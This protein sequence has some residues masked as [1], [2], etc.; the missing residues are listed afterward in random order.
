MLD[1]G[2]AA[3]LEA[4]MVPET[5]IALL[6]GNKS[7]GGI[8][9]PLDNPINDIDSIAAKLRVLDFDT[10]VLPDATF[11]DTDRA[12]KQYVRKLR[13][14]E[15]RPVGFFWYTGHGLMD[16]R[17]HT[18]YLIPTDITT[19][20]PAIFDESIGL[21]QILDL[22]SRDNQN[23]AQIVAFDAS[24]PNL[25]IEGTD[26]VP[27]GFAATHA[28][29]GMV[30]LFASSPGRP[31]YDESQA[32]PDHSP[33]AFALLE[34]LERPSPH[35][36]MLLTLAIERVVELTKK[37]SPVQQPHLLVSPMVEIR[38]NRGDPSPRVPPPAAADEKGASGAMTAV[39]REVPSQH[40]PR[41]PSL[42]EILRE[43]DLTRLSEGERSQFKELLA[44]VDPGPSS[45]T[46]YAPGLL[47]PGSGVGLRDMTNHAPDIVFPISN[48]EAYVNSQ[49]YG[50]GGRF[51]SANGR[52]QFDSANYAYP[53]RDNFCELRSFAIS[54]CPQGRGHQG[55]DIRAG[56][57]PV[58]D[59]MVN[60]DNEPVEIVAVE[61]GV[62]TTLTK[63]TTVTLRG[64]SGREWRYIAM[65]PVQSLARGARVRKGQLLGYM[66]NLMGG[67]P[68]TTF[69]LH[70]ELRTIVDGKAHFLSPYMALVRAYERRFGPGRMLQEGELQIGVSTLRR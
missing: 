16:P 67:G 4:E 30:V 26:F 15:G 25:T 70:I 69:H 31:A 13:E 57:R 33:L 34:G 28:R 5:R 60:R 29:A 21:E 10:T 54:V 2:V 68:Q 19:S 23:A 1:G 46:Y 9:P 45:F 41:D 62:I 42:P 6:I 50:A 52:G 61:E 20:G 36:A 35:H 32:A 24:R 58:G 65:K 14:A 18:N 3:R 49:L 63:N 55:V 53:W 8:I 44:K 40:Q 39:I 47:L 56:L 66:S 22:L 43:F 51:D 59:V 38:L 17:T 12:I 64:S 37:R 11:R 7:Y 48:A 27:V